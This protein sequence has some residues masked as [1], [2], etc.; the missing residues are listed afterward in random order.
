PPKERR[1]RSGAEKLSGDKRRHIRRTT[2]SHD[3]GADDGGEQQR[4]SDE[5]G[6]EAPGQ[7]H[8]GSVAA[9]RSAARRRSWLRRAYERAHKGAIDLT[10]QRIDVEALAGQERA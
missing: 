2:R 5:L 4:G 6:D 10:R 8:D 9:A 7:G 3:A 1:R